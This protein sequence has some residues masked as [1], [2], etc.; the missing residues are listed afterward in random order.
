MLK[1]NSD[2]VAQ[3]LDEFVRMAVTQSIVIEKQQQP[4]VVMLSLDEFQRLQALDD[5]YLAACV[6]QANTEGYLDHDHEIRQ[7]LAAA[8]NE[9]RLSRNRESAVRSCSVDAGR[10][11][12]TAPAEHR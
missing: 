3:Q 1:V 9:R 6:R 8:M 5:A 2:A 10:A 4:A 7:R 12:E 11:T